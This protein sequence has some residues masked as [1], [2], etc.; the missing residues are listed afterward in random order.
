MKAF[1]L[2]RVGG[3]LDV[4]C[5]VMILGAFMASDVPASSAAA[6]VVAPV[7]PSAPVEPPRPVIEKT[8]AV[9]SITTDLQRRLLNDDTKQLLA[10]VFVDGSA[11]FQGPKEL[12]LEAIPLD[13]ISKALQAYKR[14]KKGSRVHF[15]INFSQGFDIRQNGTRLLQFGLEGLGRSAGFTES[16]ALISCRAEKFTLSE[17]VAPLQ[18]EKQTDMA[19]PRSGDDVVYA[20]PVKTPLSRIL[21]ADSDAYI[22]VLTRL[23][24]DK[25]DWVPASVEK[26]VQAAIAGLKLAKNKTISF[27]FHLLDLPDKTQ[28][29]VREV[30][31]RWAKENELVLGSFGYP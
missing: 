4:T 6:A 21:L 2:L 20:Y 16:N 30:T 3:I 5:G 27:R 23:S 19:E 9:A 13:G 11:L 10:I 29:R 7:P 25:G 26:S 17:Y 22:E 14:D 18:K 28:E 8:F 24:P 1:I 31:K 12:D 15:I